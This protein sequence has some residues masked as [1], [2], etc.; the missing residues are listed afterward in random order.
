MKNILI[1]GG[2][3]VRNKDHVDHLV[4][5]V[6]WWW[7][8]PTRFYYDHRNSGESELDREKEID[9]LKMLD[10]SSYD[11]IIAKSMWTGLIAQLLWEWLL[12]DSVKLVFLWVPLRVANELE[13]VDN[14]NN[15]KCTTIIQNEFDPT[16]SYEM[17]SDYFMFYKGVEVVCVKGNSSHNYDEYEYYLSL[18]SWSYGM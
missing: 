10:L 18:I 1:L 13:F 16:G 12:S 9:N 5:Y 3:S 17:V 8:S 15:L 14:Y 6:Q 11:C 4:H 2:S 7:Y